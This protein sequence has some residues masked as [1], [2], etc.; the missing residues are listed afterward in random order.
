MPRRTPT[1]IKIT[2]HCF[3]GT[4]N[5][6]LNPRVLPV[7]GVPRSP[8][9]GSLELSVS[10]GVAVA[11]GVAVAVAVASCAISVPGIIQREVSSSHHQ[12]KELSKRSTPVTFYPSDAFNLRYLTTVVQLIKLEN[13]HRM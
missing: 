2:V 12:V 5:T 4:A 3:P 11:P 7:V 8:E 13:S 6:L 10:V 1:A 9:G